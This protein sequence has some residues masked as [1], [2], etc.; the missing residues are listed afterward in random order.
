MIAAAQCLAYKSRL[1]LN[2]GSALSIDRLLLA[3]KLSTIIRDGAAFDT[4]VDQQC[5]RQAQSEA[6]ELRELPHST[7]SSLATCARLPIHGCT[8]L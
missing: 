2:T 6:H 5:T 1:D 3:F 7:A 4:A 8:S